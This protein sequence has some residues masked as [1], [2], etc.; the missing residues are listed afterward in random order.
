MRHIRKVCHSADHVTRL[1]DTVM[2]LHPAPLTTLSPSQTAALV[3]Y[4]LF[5][6]TLLPVTSS[7]PVHN[8]KKSI[9]LAEYLQY[10]FF[11]KLNNSQVLFYLLA[12]YTNS[13]NM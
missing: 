9:S 5:S 11:G 12:L 2:T 4:R 8:N 3:K 1:T 6:V 10:E 13:L 7:Y